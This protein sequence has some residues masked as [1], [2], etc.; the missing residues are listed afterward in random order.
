MIPAT[1]FN[2]NLAVSDVDKSF[3]TK[4]V[5]SGKLVKSNSA[6][7]IILFTTLFFMSSISDALADIYS[8]SIFLK[9]SST[10]SNPTFVAYPA[11]YPSSC[12][13]LSVSLVSVGS[14]NII[15]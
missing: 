8:S 4:I 3:P 5:F 7:S 12:I 14:C 13:S 11:L 1:E 15:K 10:V 6:L 2:F 9:T